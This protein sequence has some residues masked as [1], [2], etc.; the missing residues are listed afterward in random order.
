MPCPDLANAAQTDADLDGL[1]DACD[2]CPDD[3][4]DDIDGDGVCAGFVCG[5]PDVQL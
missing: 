5:G 1:G 3:P 2:P 4:D